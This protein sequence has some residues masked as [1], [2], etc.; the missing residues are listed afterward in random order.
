M[1][2]PLRRALADRDPVYAVILGSAVNNDGHEGLF[3]A[4]SR[5][6]QESVLRQAYRA[7]GIT[8][9]RVHY[10]EAHG[11][12][13]AVGDPVEIQALGTVLAEGRR[14]DRPFSVGSIKTNIG[15]TEAASGIAGLIKA[16]LCVKHRIIPP[17]LH[18][19][20]PSPSILGMN[21]PYASRKK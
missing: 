12:G 7:A 5:Q 17:S 10:I 13:T 16:A 14:K 9:A 4:P 1:L 19:S 3:V 18:L 11:T 21:F 15:H 2:K 8:P 20:V 6:G